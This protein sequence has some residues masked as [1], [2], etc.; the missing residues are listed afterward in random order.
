MKDVPATK[1]AKLFY[2]E[3]VRF[4]LFILLC[5]VISPTAFSAFKLD[6]FTHVF[7]SFLKIFL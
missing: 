6:V 1:L 4:F 5:I 3:A 7:K 2:L